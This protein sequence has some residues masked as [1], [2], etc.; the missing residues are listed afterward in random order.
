MLQSDNFPQLRADLIREIAHNWKLEAKS[1]D[2]GR[3]FY[4][5]NE[6]ETI[7]AGAKNYIIGRKGTGK[8]AISEFILGKGKNQDGIFCEKLSFKNFPFNSNI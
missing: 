3:Y 1:E 2:V 4:H 8:T 7:L 6:V 5:T